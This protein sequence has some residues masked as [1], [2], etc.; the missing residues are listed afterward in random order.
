MKLCQLYIFLVLE[1]SKST[2]TAT[3]SEMHAQIKSRSSTACKQQRVISIQLQTHRQLA[4]AK[5]VTVSS[6]WLLPRP[7]SRTLP[8]CRPC[9]VRRPP[10]SPSEPTHCRQPAPSEST[11]LAPINRDDGA[12]LQQP[13]QSQSACTRRRPLQRR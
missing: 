12:T 1:V 8:L 9:L 3:C 5:D 7:L 10:Q 4:I 2:R 6:C 11:G 13:C